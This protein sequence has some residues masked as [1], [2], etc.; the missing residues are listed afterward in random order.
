M[1][2]VKHTNP[3]KLNH[4]YTKPNVIPQ[5]VLHPNA[6]VDL[7]REFRYGCN[8]CTGEL[9]LY[10]IEGLKLDNQNLASDLYCDRVADT[11]C[12]I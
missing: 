5:Y 3:Q 1:Q 4:R 12:D 2:L 7:L 10:I 9:L 8:D 11:G 6:L